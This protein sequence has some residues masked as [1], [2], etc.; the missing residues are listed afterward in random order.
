M[1]NHFS[2]KVTDFHDRILPEKAVLVGYALLIQVIEE[3]TD[4]QLPLPNQLAIIT[5]KHQRYNT[6]QW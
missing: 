6:E 4:R 2:H 3:H 1:N 5:D